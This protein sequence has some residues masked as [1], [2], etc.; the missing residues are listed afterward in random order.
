[1]VFIILLITALWLPNGWERANVSLIFNLHCSAKSNRLR[2]RAIK[3]LYYSWHLKILSKS[4]V[5]RDFEMSVVVEILHRYRFLS[6]TWLIYLIF[7]TLRV[8]KLQKTTIMH[9]NAYEKCLGIFRQCYHN[10]F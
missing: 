4:A 9:V 10:D 3:H 7:K 1:M 8:Q 2:G 6:V 5:S